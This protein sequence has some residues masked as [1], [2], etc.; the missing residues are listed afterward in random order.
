MPTTNCT[1]V[2]RPGLPLNATELA[3]AEENPC[4]SELKKEIKK[5]LDLDVAF[6]DYSIPDLQSLQE[7]IKFLEESGLAEKMPNE[8]VLED[9]VVSY[10]NC[11]AFLN[12]DFLMPEGI[13]EFLVQVLKRLDSKEFPFIE[14][15]ATFNESTG[16]PDSFGGVAILIT[17]EEVYSMTTESWLF[18]KKQEL[19]IIPK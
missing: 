13:I 16:D 9:L 1:G 7:Q 2:V 6:R 17:R 8:G 12:F 3:L 14:I 15:E 4:Y 18:Q 19:G 11:K 5:E 10:I